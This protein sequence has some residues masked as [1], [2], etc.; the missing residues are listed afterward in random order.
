MSLEHVSKK[1]KHSVGAAM[2][3]GGGRGGQ[4]G[5]AP[6]AP[7]DCMSVVFSFLDMRTIAIVVRVCREWHTIVANEMSCLGIKMFGCPV[8]VAHS[9][10]RILQSVFKNHIRTIQYIAPWD[11]SQLF[12]IS[13]CPNIED[14][15]GATISSVYGPYTFPSNLLACNLTISMLEFGM[16]VNLR[17]VNEIIHALSC[18]R[19]LKSL[20]VALEFDD[21][22]DAL[23]QFDDHLDFNPLIKLHHLECFSITIQIG[24]QYAQPFM[25]RLLSVI[26]NI[27]SLTDLDLFSTGVSKLNLDVQHLDYLAKKPLAK[28]QILNLR[29]TVLCAKKIKA[30]T[31]FTAFKVVQSKFIIGSQTLDWMM[32]FQKCLEFWAYA[33]SIPIDAFTTSL[34]SMTS[35]HALA[36]H[37]PRLTSM[38]MQTILQHLPHLLHLS[39]NNCERL[40]ELN[41]FEG[42]QHTKIHHLNLL[43]C[44]NISPKQLRFLKHLPLT[45]LSIDSSFTTDLDAFTIDTFTPPSSILPLL[46]TFKYTTDDEADT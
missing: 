20:E 44:R 41:C 10:L 15:Y 35:L 13:Q 5:L 6:L 1:R 25:P 17:A 26:Q 34:I 16:D 23:K 3:G 31:Q 21:T 27:Q 29:H 38:H 4:G 39:L 40:T 32:H 36:V 33:D 12:I 11:S 37:H 43:M 14:F 8:A 19:Q 24:N 9:P 2:G 42:L 7:L 18:A 22:P 28:L 46:K 45:E 30:L